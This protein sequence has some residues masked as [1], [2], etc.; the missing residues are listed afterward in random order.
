VFTAIEILG[1]N[2]RVVKFGESRFGVTTNLATL[3]TDAQVSI[4]LTILYVSI[5]TYIHKRKPTYYTLWKMD[6]V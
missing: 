3:V 1:Q 2:C 4:L 5:N 6:L